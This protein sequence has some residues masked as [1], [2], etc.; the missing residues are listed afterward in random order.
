MAEKKVT[1]AKPSANQPKTIKTRKMSVKGPIA[2]R[3]ERTY[4]CPGDCSE[5]MVTF[6]TE[7]TKAAPT[8][9]KITY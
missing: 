1:A 9:L 7:R 8:S 2:A 4:T 3:P 5:L 6:K